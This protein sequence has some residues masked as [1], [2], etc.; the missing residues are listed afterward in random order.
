MPFPIHRPYQ[1][2][3][4]SDILENSVAEPIK[5][6]SETL[7]SGAFEFLKNL[8]SVVDLPAIFLYAQAW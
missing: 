1:L 6:L 5:Q 8:T 3:P 4:L 7:A 2:S